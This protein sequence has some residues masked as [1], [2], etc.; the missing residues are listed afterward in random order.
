MGIAICTMRADLITIVV[1]TVS[2]SVS[3]T[4]L[5]CPSRKRRSSL[6]T[7]A[8][9]PSKSCDNRFSV[10]FYTSPH[11]QK[12]VVPFIWILLFEFCFNDK[13]WVHEASF[14]LCL[15]WG[16]TMAP[17]PRWASSQHRLDICRINEQWAE[18]E[19]KHPGR[20]A[21]EPDS[22]WLFGRLVV[23]LSVWNLI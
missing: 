11:C 12:W 18:N 16:A 5:V 7:F 1:A 15:G 19:H 10:W 17:P 14:L 4:T 6:K 22:V 21:W 13:H 9:R 2:H 20:W 8:R 23:C 3:L